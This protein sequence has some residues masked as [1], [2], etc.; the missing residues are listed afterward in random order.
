MEKNNLENIAKNFGLEREDLEFYGDDKAK[1]R[2]AGFAKF[3]SKP[4]GKLILV[5]AISPTPAGEGKTT[6]AIGLADA[7]NKLAPNSTVLSLREP[8]M[9]PVFGM[10]G[11]AIGGGRSRL[12]PAD[13]IN[14]HFTG[15]LA[16]ITEAN[17]LLAALIDNHIYWGN[18]LDIDPTRI[19]FRRCLDI[20]DRALREIRENASG[21]FTK[22]RGEDFTSGFNITAASEIMAIVSLAR[23]LGDLKRRLANILIGFS[24]QDQPIFARDLDAENA[25]AILLKDAINPN[26]VQTRQGTLAFVHGGPFANI[27]H[28]ASSI[29]ATKLALK[30]G[31]YAVTE[32]GFG[33]DLGAEK[34]INIVTR[35]LGVQPSV[36]VLVAT[37]RALEYNGG[38]AVTELGH[39]NL[40]ELQIGLDNLKAH[41][42]VLLAL[43][44]SV[45]V[46]INKFVSD[47]DRE[48]NIV[49]DFAKQCGVECAIADVFFEDGS[50]DDLAKLVMKTAD[51]NADSDAKLTYDLR[52]NL[53]DKII[54]VA[55]QIYGAS[56]VEFSE[57][58]ERQFREIA[59]NPAL[60]FVQNF[61]VCIAKTQYS[62]SDDPKKLAVDLRA[63]P[64]F[65]L[66]IRALEIDA[67]AEFIVALAGEIYRMPGLSRVPASAGMTIDN[68]G[69]IGGLK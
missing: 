56:S 16:A 4:N 68:Q 65:V 11:G 43:G 24:R 7:M 69:Q 33:S 26:L 25:M 23:D 1:I 31:D 51:E 42:G 53:R 57:K 5:S 47:S 48:L 67:G 6:V 12:V 54:K 58:A 27:A 64:N 8:S 19:L 39:E 3:A 17:N 9:G 37:V 35:Q 34:F 38:A 52:D 36:A 66:H 10:K 55:T 61:P 63:E 2:P 28:G 49:R 40:S 60:K 30:L 18:K 62:L 22:K 59:E 32:A 50:A 14:L 20:N 44:L 46:A 41:V 21:N 29:R 13:D 15:D 45:V